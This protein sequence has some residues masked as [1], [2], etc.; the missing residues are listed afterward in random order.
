MRAAVCHELGPPSVLQ[1]EERP[2]PEPGPGQVA[3]AVEAAGVNFVDGLFVAGRYQIKPSL[4][5]TPGNEVAG[6]IASL[7]DG[8]EGF[9]VGQRVMVTTGL[10]GFASHVVVAAHSLSPVPDG[11]DAA[12]AATFN[13]SFSTCLYALRER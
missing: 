10:G 1:V 9:E 5:F 3:V 7:G 6:R 4:P 11:L 2:D 12:R 8:V 13:Q